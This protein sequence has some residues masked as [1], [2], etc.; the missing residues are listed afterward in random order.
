MNE[1]LSSLDWRKSSY[2]NGQANCVEVAHGGPVVA[3]R[4]S[5]N[6]DGPV[7]VFGAG[8]WRAFVAGI[9][10]DGLNPS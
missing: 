6:P 8:E 1:H 9:T 4:D 7:L 5:K 2:S 10:A 3:V